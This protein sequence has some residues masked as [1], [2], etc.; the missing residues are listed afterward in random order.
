MVFYLPSK[1]DLMRYVVIIGLTGLGKLLLKVHAV[2]AIRD[3][4]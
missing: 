4:L 3:K 2:Y 1:T